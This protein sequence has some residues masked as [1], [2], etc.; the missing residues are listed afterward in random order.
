MLAHDG[1]RFNE[2]LAPVI[3][4]VKGKDVAVDVD[5]HPKSSTTSE[6]LKK[7]PSLFKE[8]GLVTAGSAS[9]SPLMI[10]KMLSKC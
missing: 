8:N 2:E 3:L 6:N 5:E 7:L 4:K 10:L 9:V 1:G